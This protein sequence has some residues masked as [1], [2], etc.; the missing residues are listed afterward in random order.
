[1]PPLRFGGGVDRLAHLLIGAAAAD[2]GDGAVDLPVARVRGVLQQR[3]D[4]HYHAAL[5]VA[6]L[7]HLLVDPG[8]LHGM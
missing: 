7:R 5:T 4:R 2:V 8:L 3:G 1:M 6:A